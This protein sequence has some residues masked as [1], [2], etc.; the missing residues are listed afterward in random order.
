MSTNQRTALS[1]ERKLD[2]SSHNP[3]TNPIGHEE[4]PYI[5][6][7]KQKVLNQMNTIGG[8]SLS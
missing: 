8:I 6:K 5:L 3:L 1:F 7:Q 2:F 4:N